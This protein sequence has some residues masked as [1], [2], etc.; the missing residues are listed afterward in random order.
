MKHVW[1]ALLTLLALAACRRWVKQ[2]TG[3]TLEAGY[4]EITLKRDGLS[5]GLYLYCLSAGNR[6][7]TRRLLVQE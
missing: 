4:H 6:Q 5:P 3:G 1:I 2:I 7:H